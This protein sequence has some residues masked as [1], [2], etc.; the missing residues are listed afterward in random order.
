[1]SSEIQDSY[2]IDRP[3]VGSAW[4]VDSA[5][6]L[7]PAMTVNDAEPDTRKADPP[8]TET[9]RRDPP[10]VVEAVEKLQ[11]G[12]DVEGQFR[13]LYLASEPAVRK[14]AASFVPAEAVD[15]LVQEAMVR[16]YRGVKTFRFDSTFHVWL[17]TLVKNL[18]RNTHRDWGTAKAATGL[19]AAS[20]DALFA[21]D[22]D[23][24]RPTVG[25]PVSA[26][27]DPLENT[28]QSERREHLETA[29]ET[30]PERMRQCLMLHHFHGYRYREIADLQGVSVGT[31]KKQIIEGRRRL[32]PALS[33]FAKLFG[34][35]LVLLV[36]V[37]CAWTGTAWTG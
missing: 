12:D 34:L 29:L 9:V 35:F 27:P 4:N 16:V 7:D 23:E 3:A 26:E 37:A 8:E 25:E 2:R 24:H 28:L 6:D 19:R 14:L 22:D 21:G 17:T 31:V 30:L 33:A 18:I 15:D 5:E 10:W 1:M 20:L 13:R 32:R 36:A 11:A